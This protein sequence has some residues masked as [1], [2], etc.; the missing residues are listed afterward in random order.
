MPRF[1]LKGVV[2]SEWDR[3]PLPDE[4]TDSMNIL[5]L[6][7]GEDKFLVATVP[8]NATD[9]EIEILKDVLTE[10]SSLPVVIVTEG[11]TLEV[12]EVKQVESAWERL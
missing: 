11:I 8:G 1:I 5:E 9:E 3:S 12:V 7:E 10:V 4:L 6:D 2:A